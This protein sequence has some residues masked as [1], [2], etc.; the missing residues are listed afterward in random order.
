MWK[1]ALK[2]K[3]T[4]DLIDEE[5]INLDDVILTKPVYNKVKNTIEKAIA[6]NELVTTNLKGVGKTTAVIKLA[7]KYDLSVVTLHSE[8]EELSE[9]FNYGRIYSLQMIT[10]NLDDYKNHKFI[11]DCGRNT[12]GVINALRN[13]GLNVIS[14]VIC[15]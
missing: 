5:I 14:G 6:R 9:K 10:G 15:N 11:V 7:K 4:K 3:G 1:Q 13:N 12:E 2:L 8:V